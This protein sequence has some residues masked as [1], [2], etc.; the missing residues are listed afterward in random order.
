MSY[1]EDQYSSGNSVYDK[2]YDP[3]DDGSEDSFDCDSQLD[4]NETAEETQIVQSSG[5]CCL[6]GMIEFP[7][8][9]QRWSRTRLYY[10]P[11]FGQM[12]SFGI[13][14]ERLT[15][16]M[17][18]KTFN[19]M[20]NQEMA[21]FDRKEN[22]VGA[23]CARLSGDASSV[24]GVA[25]VQIGTC[26][27]FLSTFVLT[28]AI[29]LYFDWK[30]TLVLLSMCPF[31][32]FSIYFKQKTLQ[33]DAQKNQK[34]LEKSSK[35]AIEAIGNIRTVVSL[36]CE[37]VF[38]DLFVEELLPYQRAAKKKCHFRGIV[39]GMARSLLFFSYAIGILY[40]AKLIVDGELDYG[41][42]FK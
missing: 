29:S 3:E 7:G 23:L 31:I 22:G 17:R 40:S 28:G 24:Q 42:V 6:G 41:T 18:K 39:F 11:I 21:W 1:L 14:G 33:V 19:A 20:L 13:A 38:I 10:H 27:N 37:N 26:I 30:L 9:K 15:L 4:E 32:F 16:R 34:M 25:G 8:L 36:G 5:L 2:A 35:I 12:F